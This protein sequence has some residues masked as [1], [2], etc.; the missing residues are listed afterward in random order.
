[1]AIDRLSMLFLKKI[2]WLHLNFNL[3]LLVVLDCVGVS[4]LTKLPKFI[5]TVEFGHLSVVADYLP[6]ISVN[7]VID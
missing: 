2:I 3:Y 5:T 1:M 4:I 6:N 7:L